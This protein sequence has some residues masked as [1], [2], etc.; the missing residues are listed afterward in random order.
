MNEI[1]LN[2]ALEVARKYAYLKAK[3][4]KLEEYKKILLVHIMKEIGIKYKNPISEQKAMALV[5]PEYKQLLVNIKD[6]HI[7]E[8]ECLWELNKFEADTDKFVSESNFDRKN[9][10]NIHNN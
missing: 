2:Q 1:I 4:L 10:W 3:R 5:T 9:N 6:C 8:T 7:N